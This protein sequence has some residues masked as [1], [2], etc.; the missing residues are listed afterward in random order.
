MQQPTNTVR[1]SDRFIYNLWAHWPSV[2]KPR[3]QNCSL[4]YKC[5]D[6]GQNGI[7]N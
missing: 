7:K 5:V 1:S 3:I 2:K 4:M 6:G